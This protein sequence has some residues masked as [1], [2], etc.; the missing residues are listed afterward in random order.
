LSNMCNIAYDRKTLLLKMDKRKDR[1][2]E[3]KWD[4]LGL[5]IV[6]VV[7]IKFSN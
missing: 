6:G 3:I 7:L 2:I 1:E 4:K 5:I